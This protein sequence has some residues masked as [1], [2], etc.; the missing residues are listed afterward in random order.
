MKLEAGWI[1]DNKEALGI[2]P[3]RICRNI[4]NFIFISIFYLG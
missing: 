2:I 1:F 4:Q 3:A